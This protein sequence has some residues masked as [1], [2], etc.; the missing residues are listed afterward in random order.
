MTDSGLAWI[1]RLGPGTPMATGAQPLTVSRV[2]QI[3]TT[4]Q[5]ASGVLI[6]HRAYK[7]SSFPLYKYR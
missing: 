3:L 6:G 5:G 7:D 2:T 1:L 4:R